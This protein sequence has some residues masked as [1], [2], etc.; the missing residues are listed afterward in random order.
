MAERRT[1][2]KVE[3][4]TSLQRITMILLNELDITTMGQRQ[5]ELAGL[6]PTL[7]AKFR[8]L[9]DSCSFP[10]LGRNA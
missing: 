3:A 8:E 5:E 4:V 6:V 1:Q 9:L 10:N 7:I 2:K